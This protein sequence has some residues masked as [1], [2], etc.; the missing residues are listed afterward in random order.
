[1]SIQD[2]LKHYDKKNGVK[3]LKNEN[4][5][6]ND[7]KKLIK[8]RK[9]IKKWDVLF[10]EK[11]KTILE[12]VNYVGKYIALAATMKGYVSLV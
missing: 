6:I 2:I 11:R 7:L 3:S 1:M 12:F 4:C 8:D 10:V 5:K 9:E